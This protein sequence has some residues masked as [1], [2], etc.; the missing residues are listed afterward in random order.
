MPEQSPQ[1]GQLEELD[2]R[3]DATRSTAA[4]PHS[5]SPI[6]GGSDLVRKATLTSELRVALMRDDHSS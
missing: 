1:I 6:V 3:P 5:S 4:P 2:S